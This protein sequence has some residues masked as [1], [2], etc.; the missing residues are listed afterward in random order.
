MDINVGHGGLND[1]RKHLATSKHQEMLKATSGTSSLKALIRPSPLEESITRAELLFASFIAEHNL[2]FMLADHFTH[3]SKAM[4][5]IAKLQKG[6]A[7]LLPVLSKVN[8]IPTS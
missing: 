8:L 1:V 5:P 3:L 6:S 2:P 7:V 4:F